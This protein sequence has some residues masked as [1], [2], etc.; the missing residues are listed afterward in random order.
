[1]EHER[2]FTY[3]GDIVEGLLAAL[4]HRG[5]LDGEVIN[6]GSER[7]ESTAAGIR[8]VEEL[9]GAASPRAGLS[10]GWCR[11]QSKRTQ[12]YIRRCD[13]SC[14]LAR[15]DEYLHSIGR[16]DWPRG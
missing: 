13:Y 4:E 2:S 12:R 9:M 3:V 11:F 7:S 5:R 8:I 16:P 10:L 15:L 1:M 14:F 6:L